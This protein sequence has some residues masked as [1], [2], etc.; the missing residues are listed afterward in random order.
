MINILPYLPERSAQ[1]RETGVTM[2][3]DKGLSYRQAEDFIAHSGHWL[4]RM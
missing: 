4:P 1:P 3:M 2:M